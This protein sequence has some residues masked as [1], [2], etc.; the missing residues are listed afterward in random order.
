MAQN[1]FSPI[2][3]VPNFVYKI[4]SQ[5][6]LHKIRWFPWE[7]VLTLPAFSMVKSVFLL[8]SEKFQKSF[9]S[10]FL[11]EI[12]LDFLDFYLNFWFLF[13]VTVGPILAKN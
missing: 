9:F 10:S 1:T 12:L 7:I 2:Y 5:H 13:H 6:F 4:N 3:V 11:V 8:F